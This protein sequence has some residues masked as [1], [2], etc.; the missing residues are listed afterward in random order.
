MKET[1]L[2]PEYLRKLDEET[3]QEIL[4]TLAPEERL[5][6]LDPAVI[7]AYLRQQQAQDAAAHP[8]KAKAARRKTKQ[9]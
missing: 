5:A 8:P 9:A 2:T 4:A 1:T 3:R 7:E 6:G